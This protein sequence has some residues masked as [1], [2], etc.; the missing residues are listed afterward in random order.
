MNSVA[1]SSLNPPPRESI[2]AADVFSASDGLLA[3][4]LPLAS[5]LNELLSDLPSLTTLI[6]AT[7]K[8]ENA[9]LSAKL[10]EIAETLSTLTE[11]VDPNE[12]QAVRAL[13]HAD[14]IA[15]DRITRGFIIL[16]N[17]EI[18][19][20]V[21]PLSPKEHVELAHA[22]EEKRH[23]FWT[24]L[25]EVPFVQR[26][27]IAILNSLETKQ[28][29]ISTIIFPPRTHEY[30]SANKSTRDSMLWEST[31]DSLEQIRKLGDH[32]NAGIGSDY[33]KEVAAILARTP[34]APEHAL[35]LASEC[36][37]K[38]Q[39]LIDAEIKDSSQNPPVEFQASLA[40][41]GASALKVR[42][43]IAELN[44]LEEPYIRLKNY[45]VMSLT[46]LAHSVINRKKLTNFKE[47]TDLFQSGVVGIMRGVERY[48]PG[49]GTK[50]TTNV[51]EWIAQGVRAERGVGAF[52]VSVPLRKQQAFFK[53]RALCNQHESSTELVEIASQQGISIQDAFAFI[54]LLSPARSLDFRPDESGA[55]SM[56]LH[57]LVPDKNTPE[58][59]EAVYIED[60]KREIS[61]AFRNLNL[62]ERQILSLAYGLEGGTPKT[63][64][65]IGVEIGM[66]TERVKNFRNR[67]LT[68]L[69]R[70]P[71]AQRINEL[72]GTR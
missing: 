41:F 32:T 23:A 34:L 11:Q 70:A 64:A 46:N 33:R 18:P 8:E 67:S 69:K 26:E 56:S 60:L 28:G 12:D 14:I 36:K 39:S 19:E 1:L 43:F 51:F 71:D 21:G 40:D 63:D 5:K 55:T 48:D 27:T 45:M 37:R 42:G 62:T 44:R 9:L 61:M 58:N 25:Y 13:E 3:P 54:A 38:A 66:R 52:A 22:M 4:M 24:K 59:D 20:G 65:E 2:S 49:Y 68:R 47:K 29:K 53:V 6:M 57:Q 72:Y 17:K 7:S 35:V 15:N 16:R 50:L 30:R 31:R 10:G